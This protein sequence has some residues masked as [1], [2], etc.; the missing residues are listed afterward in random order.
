MNDLAVLFSAQPKIEL[1]IPDLSADR[2]LLG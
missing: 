2:G 1:K